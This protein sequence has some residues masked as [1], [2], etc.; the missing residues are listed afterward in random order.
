MTFDY[1]YL[2]GYKKVKTHIWLYAIILLPLLFSF[3]LYITWVIYAFP[4]M[5]LFQPELNNANNSL[6]LA[7]ILL[8]IITITAYLSSLS[9]AKG[10]YDISSKKK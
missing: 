1:I 6:L 3:Q 5:V 2:I 4:L 10:L 7:A 8:S 9:V